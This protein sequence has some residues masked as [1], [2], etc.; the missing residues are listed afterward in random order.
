VYNLNKNLSFNI[1]ILTYVQ[2]D[3][4]FIIIE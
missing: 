2:L 4:I 1:A 3:Q